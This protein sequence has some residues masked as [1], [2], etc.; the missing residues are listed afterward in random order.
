LVE[1][2]KD[3]GNG[4]MRILKLLNFELNNVLAA[5]CTTF[6][7]FLIIYHSYN[8]I[9]TNFE[10]ICSLLGI[11]IPSSPILT[12][13]DLTENSV[14]LYWFEPKDNKKSIF[15]LGLKDIAKLFYYY[16][17][18]PFHQHRKSDSSQSN[19]DVDNTLSDLI[20]V[21]KQ[22]GENTY[23]FALN[24]NTINTKDTSNTTNTTTT[25][26]NNKL[27]FPK[28]TSTTNFTTTHYE[29]NSELTNS[30]QDINTD[31]QQSLSS[32]EEDNKENESDNINNNNNNNNNKILNNKREKGKI[33]YI[34]KNGSDHDLNSN[35]KILVDG[36][37][38]EI[39][40][41]ADKINREIKQL[42]SQINPMDNATGLKLFLYKY[43][44]H[45]RNEIAYQVEVNGYIL[46]EEKINEKH[47]IINGLKPSTS[48]KIRIWSIM[49]NRIKSPSSFINVQTLKSYTESLSKAKVSK[50]N[51]NEKPEE[52]IEDH[53]KTIAK[54]DNDI[55]EINKEFEKLKRQRLEFTKQ[56]N[57]INDQYKEEEIPLRKQLDELKIEKN[58]VDEEKLQYKG[59]LKELKEEKRRVDLVKSQR[60]QGLKT[61]ERGKQQIIDRCNRT[62]A[63]INKLQKDLQRLEEKEQS[64]NV[65]YENAK[66][67]YNEEK[68]KYIKEQNKLKDKLKEEKKYHKSLVK[69]LNDKKSKFK[70]FE[71][72]RKKLL[73]DSRERNKE[74]LK[75][76]E[77]YKILSKKYK[78]LKE[79]NNSLKNQLKFENKEKIKLL[80]DL[81]E[82]HQ[83]SD[84]DESSDIDDNDD[85]MLEHVDSSISD[86]LASNSTLSKSTSDPST[87]TPSYSNT[88]SVMSRNSSE[89]NTALKSS[90]FN[91]FNQ[92]DNE[93]YEGKQTD[94]QYG[95]SPRVSSPIT[96]VTNNISFS[97]R[98]ESHFMNNNKKNNNSIK[99]RFYSYPLENSFNSNFGVSVGSYSGKINNDTTSSLF[100]RNLR[101]YNDPIS[102]S[103]R[104]KQKQN[105][106]MKNLIPFFSYNS[107]IPTT[108]TNTDSQLLTTSLEDD[109]LT[110]INNSNNNANNK[111]KSINSSKP[112]H[113]VF[114]IA[115]QEKSMSPLLSHLPSSN[116]NS[117]VNKVSSTVDSHFSPQISNLSSHILNEN[118]T[119]GTSSLQTNPEF[120]S[121]SL[122]GY[123][124]SSL[125]SNIL[126][127]YNSMGLTTQGPV[128]S[129]LNT[130]S[131][132]TSINNP[133]SL[134]NGSKFLNGNGSSTNTNGAIKTK[135]DLTGA[136]NSLN[137]FNNNQT[138]HESPSF[139]S[140]VVNNTKLKGKET[141]LSRGHSIGENNLSRNNFSPM[142]SPQVKSS[143]LMSG[144]S[145]TPYYQNLNRS[146]DVSDLLGSSSISSSLPSTTPGIPVTT[147]I[148]NE[149]TKDAIEMDSLKDVQRNSFA[150]TTSSSSNY[151]FNNNN[152]FSSFSDY[153]KSSHI[154]SY[155]SFYNQTLFNHGITGSSYFNEPSSTSAFNTINGLNTTNN[156]NNNQMN[157]E[158][159]ED[160]DL[161]FNYSM[162]LSD[163]ESED[164]DT[165]DIDISKIIDLSKK[166]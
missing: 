60:E 91:L 103:P 133:D 159:D 137:G 16:I 107:Y 106:K 8:T 117:N 44:F 23:H 99:S 140:P 109:L 161:N 166:Q 20:S 144:F 33:G 18:Y 102:S 48:Y 1:D 45:K 118:N 92:F 64:F 157:D 136:E 150:H 70:Q 36:K 46:N 76:D 114:N 10:L 30:L 104:Q 22:H 122:N 147:T 17:T 3:F 14:E 138:Q 28:S 51:I 52:S 15:D 83:Q 130:N 73:Q 116:L 66:K 37:E 56:V 26:T 40:Q 72:S 94:K 39:K 95:K 49:N 32:L 149:K 142:V 110:D 50:T 25:T 24:N 120:N 9:K 148:A 87:N 101:T 134:I 74:K 6:L 152:Y 146:N 41:F 129:S 65:T 61:K 84:S 125:F 2:K 145:F 98:N 135:N 97:N 113:N 141:D 88:N 21:S 139:S 7:I 119:I 5:H 108:E 160:I 154:P 34:I 19:S 57:D 53:L 79:K 105:P 54:I 85:V 115:S 55:N 124:Q 75:V 156:N 90:E 68:K 111:V 89:D 128:S 96:Q 112:S 43:G 81:N 47:I 67:E 100:E 63:D 77:E 11:I 164:L 131:I 59:E 27:K 58:E 29:I 86:D 158:L 127:N 165:S 123:N 121:L 162:E 35:S 38:V 155:P 62:Q 13:K 143:S 31:N 69:E 78:E 163:F 12:I 151:L 93:T 80:Q 126:S 71:L 42:E 82:I 132:Y 153:P 4:I